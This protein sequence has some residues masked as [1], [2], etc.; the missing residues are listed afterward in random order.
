LSVVPIALKWIVI[1]RFKPTTIRIWSLAYVRFW[2]VKQSI[3]LSPMN[4]FVGSPLYTLYLRALGARVGRNVVVL[5]TH[6]PVCIDLLTVGDDTVVRKDVWWLGYRAEAGRIH[7]GPITLGRGVVVGDGSV[8]DIG[9]S[10]LDGAQL[11]H[12]SSLREG[13]VVPAGT[14]YHGSP[15]EAADGT[16]ATVEPRRCTRR[17]RAVYCAGQVAG[18]VAFE[19]PLAIAIAAVLFTVD[20]S[21]VAGSLL[22]FTSLLVSGLVVTAAVPRLFARVVHVDKVY[23]LYGLHYWAFQSVIRI[24]NSQLFNNLFGDSSYIVH[25]LRAIGFDL[26]DVVQTGSNFGVAQKHDSP[27]LCHVGRGTMVSDGLSMVNADFSSSSF[28][29][30]HASIGTGNFLGNNIVYPPAS[31]TA[32]NCLLA[33]KVMVP[34]TG[35]PRRDVGLLGSPP[36]EIPRRSR[37]ERLV[38]EPADE[39]EL[40]RRLARKNRSNLLTMAYFLVSRWLLVYATVWIV[41]GAVD[42]DQGFDQL[43]LAATL[44]GVLFFTVV[45]FVLLERL[46]LGFRRLSP[47]YCSIYEPYFWHHERYWKLNDFGYLEVFNGTPYKNVI[48]RMLG[49]RIG[50]QVFDDGCAIVEKTLATVGDRCTLGA[51]STLQSHSLEDA[52]FK[53]DHIAIGARSTIGTNAF[54][55]YAVTVGDDV[56]LDNDAFLMK[57]EAP[58]AGSTWYGNPARRVH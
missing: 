25:Y 14:R 51:G 18:R 17:R 4:A 41:V 49:V 8:L 29:L 22:A 46:S 20:M 2:V 40:R 39:T 45:Y 9:T 27:F 10:L 32:D 56:L 35:E 55:H 21:N 37:R 48:W 54:V 34:T 1:G 23:R 7:T 24:S 3:A 43:A 31:T 36:F 47:Q 6:A 5:S 19:F 52:T 53:S 15:G 57:G 13:Q 38:D 44:L 50:K 28:R 30:S 12:A 26:S 16:C 42:R 33:T 11:A 58:A